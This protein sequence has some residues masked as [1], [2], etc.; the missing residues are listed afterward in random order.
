LIISVTKGLE[1]QDDGQLVLLPDVVASEFPLSS[2]DFPLL[3]LLID[4]VVYAKPLVLP[5]DA[6]LGEITRGS[7]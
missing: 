2:E 4:V 7:T 5:L 1:A 6:F 3:R